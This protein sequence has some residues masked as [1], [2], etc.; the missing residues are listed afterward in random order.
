MKWWEQQDQNA[1]YTWLEGIWKECSG[2]GEEESCF[3][4]AFWGVDNPG[5]P[6]EEI[7][8]WVYFTECDGNFVE[9]YVS[10]GETTQAYCIQ[11]GTLDFSQYGGSAIDLGTCLEYTGCINVVVTSPPPPKGGVSKGGYF[12]YIDCFGR[13]IEEY[14][15]PGNTVQYCIQQDSAYFYGN[16]QVTILGPC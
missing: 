4:V 3:S 12:G 8:G 16:V 10:P 14:I 11:K 13:R 1:Y 5:F 15:V 9:L 7:G 6:K 2:S